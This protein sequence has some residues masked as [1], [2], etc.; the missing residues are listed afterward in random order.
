[1]LAGKSLCV[2]SC[3]VLDDAA[4]LPPE[5]PF[6]WD[7][8]PTFVPAYERMACAPADNSKRDRLLPVCPIKSCRRKTHKKVISRHLWA[9]LRLQ[10]NKGRACL[11]IINNMLILLF[12][13]LT[14][15][16]N[17]LQR[18]HFTSLSCKTLM[19]RP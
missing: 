3:G 17:T 7:G 2:E 14:L 12:T 18:L 1:M 13:C 10:C 16:F 5:L 19:K 8:Y 9:F 11:V 4:V 15:Q 6:S